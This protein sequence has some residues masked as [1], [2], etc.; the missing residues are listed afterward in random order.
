MCSVVSITASA[1]LIDMD[2][3]DRPIRG[4]IQE[5]IMDWDGHFQT[6]RQRPLQDFTYVFIDSQLLEFDFLE[7][8]CNFFEVSY[9]AQG[10]IDI[11]Y[12]ERIYLLVHDSGNIYVNITAQA[13][14]GIS[15]VYDFDNEVTRNSLFDLVGEVSMCAIGIWSFDSDMY[16]LLHE[17]QHEWEGNLPVYVIER[18]HMI[19]G[20]DPLY[21]YNYGVSGFSNPF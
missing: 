4:L 6:A 16:T 19:S 12:A 10:L 9:D 11:L 21:V 20:P 15:Y 17:L 8:F 14:N 1:A 7:K 13:L 3:H 2:I 5:L 18:E